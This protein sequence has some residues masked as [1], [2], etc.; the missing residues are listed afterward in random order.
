MP[1]LFLELA[2]RLGPYLIVLVIG[3]G[4]GWGGAWKIQSLRL[5]EC[6]LDQAALAQEFRDYKQEIKEQELQQAELANA[7]RITAAADYR[8]LN[9]ELDKQIRDGEAYRRCVAAGKCGP[10]A[11]C[12]QNDGSGGAALRVPPAG[13]V[14]G[15]R[16]DAIPAARNPAAEVA[17]DC[18]RTT[19]LLNQLQRDIE[20]QPGYEVPRGG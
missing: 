6:Q 4:L 5:N 7:Q 19:L 9:D 13:G 8:R 17:G 18:A 2:K 15:A 1:T 16:A 14:D 11:V 3:L 10:V 12:V 20:N